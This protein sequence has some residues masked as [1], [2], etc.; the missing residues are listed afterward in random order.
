MKK[1]F[2][3]LAVVALLAACGAEEA[4]NNANANDT[5]T[6]VVDTNVNEVAPVVTTAETTNGVDADTTNLDSDTATTLDADTSEVA[7]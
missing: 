5:T 1:V 7:E 4:N 3:S 2:L 6:T